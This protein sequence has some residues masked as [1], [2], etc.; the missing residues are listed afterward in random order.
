MSEPRLTDLFP[1]QARAL[2]DVKGADLVERLG[3]WIL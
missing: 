2:L 3:A 1:E